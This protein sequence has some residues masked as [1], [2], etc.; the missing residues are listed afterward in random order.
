M[1]LLKEISGE[2]VAYS[3]RLEKIA[4]KANE[5]LGQISEE[6]RLGLSTIDKILEANG[7]P[8][9]SADQNNWKN[10]QPP[11]QNDSIDFT[12]QPNVQRPVLNK[13]TTPKRIHLIYDP[14]SGE[15]QKV[16]KTPMMSRPPA[17]YT[18]ANAQQVNDALKH[19][20][21]INPKL[22]DLLVNGSMSIWI[23]RNPT[24]QQGNVQSLK[25]TS[26]GGGAT[27]KVDMTPDRLANAQ[28]AAGKMSLA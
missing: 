23:P 13:N 1:K 2:M 25:L 24:S 4:E 11:Q 22:A 20:E 18:E 21:R 19:L 5:W 15:I 27:N 12:P 8:Y 3:K 17:E 10:R 6:K 14:S 16:V 26:A 7:D 28:S 9:N